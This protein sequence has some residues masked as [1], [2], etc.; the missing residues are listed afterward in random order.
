MAFGG[1]HQH[2][3]KFGDANVGDAVFSN[4]PRI[5]FPQRFVG[6]VGVVVGS[7]QLRKGGSRLRRQSG[8]RERP[9]THGSETQRAGDG[10]QK[11]SSIH[12][13]KA[14]SSRL[15]SY[16]KFA[17][18]ATRFWVINSPALLPYLTSPARGTCRANLNDFR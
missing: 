11:G 17:C 5:F 2:P 18:R 14:S 13:S 6:L 4:H 15:F 10:F 8:E 1:L 7:K 16:L 12:F 9:G 3:S